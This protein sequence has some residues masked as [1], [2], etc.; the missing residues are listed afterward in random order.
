MSRPEAAGHER[1]LLAEVCLRLA[2]VAEPRYSEEGIAG[3]C[4]LRVS[5]PSRQTRARCKAVFRYGQLIT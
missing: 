1:R 2:R 4:L 3:Q 5:G